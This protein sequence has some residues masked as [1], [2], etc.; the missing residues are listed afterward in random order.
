M[1]KFT[2]KATF[3]LP[4]TEPVAADGQVGARAAKH[5]ADKAD[6]R[7]GPDRNEEPMELGLNKLPWK[8]QVGIF[9]AVAVAAAGRLLLVLRAGRAGT[10]TTQRAD[11]L[12]ALQAEINKGTATARQLPAFRQEVAELEAR[13]DNLRAVLP[14]EK[15]VGDLL[16]RLQTLATQSNLHDQAASS[17]RRSS[18]SRR[19]PSGRSIWSSTGR[20]TTSGVFFDRVS[21]FP[22]IINVRHVQHQGEGQA[23]ARI[24]HRRAQCMATTFVLVEAETPQRR[25]RRKGAKP[26]APPAKKAS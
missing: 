13:L 12:D 19:T 15:D 20:T 6:R 23:A 11:K 2:L 14:E 9:L 16:R 3:A 4:G 5:D 25:R 24:D 8:V 26:A 7:S 21:K 1:I 17:R 10:V 22:R 18:R